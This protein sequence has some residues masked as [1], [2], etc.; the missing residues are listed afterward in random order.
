MRTK[1]KKAISTLIAVT[2]AFSILVAFSATASATTTWYVNTTGNDTTGAGSAG[3]PWKTITHSLT[4]VSAGDTIIVGPG[5]YLEWTGAVSA[6]CA[7]QI[8]W[9]A[10]GAGGLTI[11]SSDGP[12]NT[13]IDCGSAGS[14][15]KIVSNNI[16]FDGFTVKNAYTAVGQVSAKGHNLSN[17]IITDFG[18]VGL[19]LMA[20]HNCEFS[21]ITIHGNNGSLPYGTGSGTCG[22]GMVKGIDMQEYGSGG[23]TYNSFEDITIYDIET[24]GT[25]GY[26]LGIY[27]E[28]NNAATH[29]SNDNT[30]TNVTIYNMTGPYG[31]QG[32]Y[33]YGQDNSL[34]AIENATFSGGNIHDCTSK[35]IYV[36]G[37][38]KNLSISG[39]DITNNGQHG[40][41]IRHYYGTPCENI[42]I[43]CN[44]IVGNTGY[45]VKDYE[46]DNDVDAT[47]NWWG[48]HTGPYHPTTN[49]S[50]LGD[51]VS[52]NVDF[53]PWSFTPDPCETKTMG[54]WKNHEDS[55]DAVLDEYGPIYLG[56][57]MVDGSDNATAVFNNAKNKNANTMLAAQL[58]AAKLNV[59][60]LTHLSIAYCDCIDDVIDHADGILSNHGY[61]GPDDPGTVPKEDKEEANGYKDDLDEHN[62]GVCPC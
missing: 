19:E 23:N 6:G 35:G 5:T 31:G 56:D 22:D 34:P 42:D 50:G 12:E 41:G 7:V 15:V 36:L 9:Y 25:W 45:G 62:E 17:L 33:M 8:P 3:N 38:C 30:F 26:S 39:F 11:R 29:P 57:F 43:H 40:V 20:V 46:G 16:T 44:N 27:W 58:L 10:E 49:P 53:D 2:V 21:N 55:V 54:F 52:D 60:H 4:Q 28:G 61:N 13:I 1:N 18:T 37:G 51:K 32:I 48:D 14:G 24:T 59:A 47:C